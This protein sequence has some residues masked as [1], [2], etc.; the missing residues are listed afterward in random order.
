MELLSG[1]I[2]E[3]SSVSLSLSL[4][5]KLHHWDSL[6]KPCHY[7]LLKLASLNYKV[8]QLQASLNLMV[9]QLKASLNLKGSRLQTSLNLNEVQLKTMKSYSTTSLWCFTLD[10]EMSDVAKAAANQ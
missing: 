7:S 9:S 6:L 4:I 3:A 5:Q 8:S 10:T 2:T 1:A